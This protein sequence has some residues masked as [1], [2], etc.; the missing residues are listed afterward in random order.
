MLPDYSVLL[1]IYKSESKKNLETSLDSILMQTYSPKEVIIV[2]DGPISTELMEEIQK[3]IIKSHFEVKVVKLTNNV[4]LGL[5]LKEGTKHVSTDWIG[6]MDTDDIAIPTRF[7]LQLSIASLHPD[8]AI[9]GGQVGEFQGTIENIVGYRKVPLTAKQII[10][11]SKYRNPFNHPTVIINRDK[12][13]DVGGYESFKLFE[14][15]YLWMKLLSKEFD[16]LN[17]DEILD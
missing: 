5:A 16:V 14:D 17:M 13:N 2:Q 10:K 4:G 12:L 15:Y 3:F 7:E 9:I 6:R 1:S 11:F 8:Y